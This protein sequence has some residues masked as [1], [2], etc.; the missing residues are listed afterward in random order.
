MTWIPIISTVIR[1]KDIKDAGKEL[2]FCSTDWLVLNRTDK[3]RI[4]RLKLSDVND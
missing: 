4:R 3:E 2:G 1:N